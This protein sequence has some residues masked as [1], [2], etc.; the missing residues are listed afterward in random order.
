MWLCF[1]LVFWFISILPPRI[2]TVGEKSHF[3]LRVCKELRVRGDFIVI[4]ALVVRSSVNQNL[5]SR[6][7]IVLQAFGVDIF[8]LYWFLAFTFLQVVDQQGIFYLSQILFLIILL[9]RFI[10]I[11]WALAFSWSVLNYYFWIFL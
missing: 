7:V 4:P 6:K 11:V 2:A 3:S 5:N 8:R 10:W 9:L 1:T